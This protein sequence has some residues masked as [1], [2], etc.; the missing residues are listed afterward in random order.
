MMMLYTQL[1]SK[2]T[3][4]AA[5]L[6]VV[7]VVVVVEGVATVCFGNVVVVD[8]S[9][10]VMVTAGGMGLL[11]LSMAVVVAIVSVMGVTKLML[12]VLISS[13]NCAVAI[14]KNRALMMNK[15]I[16]FIM[17]VFFGCKTIKK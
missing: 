1:V 3:Y 9:V 8:T 16:F 13:L 4:L 6:L 14:T 5:S 12:L 17:M 11:S 2:E 10:T 7:V 15:M